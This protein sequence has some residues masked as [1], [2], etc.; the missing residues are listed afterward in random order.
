MGSH[1]K[2]TYTRYTLLIIGLIVVLLGVSLM[3]SFF[4]SKA[5]QHSKGGIPSGSAVVSQC[6][7]I[8]YGDFLPTIVN[9]KLL[10]KTQELCNPA[11]AVMH[12]GISRT[13]LWSAEHLMRH[14]K[15][16]KADRTND[17]RA[18]ERLGSDQ[19]AEL[20]DYARS[21]YDRGHMSPSADFTT[22]DDVSQSFLLSNMV[23]QN[24]T[25]NRGLWSAIEGATRHLA[26][27]QGE[28]YVIT[29]PLFTGESLQRL[30]GRVLVPTM[31]YKAIYD[32]KSGQAAAYV[33]HNQEGDSYEVVSLEKLEALAG[34]VLFPTLSPHVKASVMSLPQPLMKNGFR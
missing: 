16:E 15:N 14:S 21:G 4:G 5:E 33:V 24:P 3:T 32:P 12:S 8:Y 19:R 11:Y 6:R 10:P 30:N 18:D 17:F 22:S 7:G 23:P 2:E 9:A 13:P 25:N 20:E 28:L 1:F 26:N 29:G 31:L 34:I 27:T